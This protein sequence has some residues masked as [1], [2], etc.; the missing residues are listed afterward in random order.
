MAEDLAGKLYDELYEL[1]DHRLPGVDGI[2]DS[3]IHKIDTFLE[4]Y[5]NYYDLWMV[6]G[7]AIRLG[8]FLSE[9]SFDDAIDTY[10]IAMCIDPFD[11]APY[12]E[13]AD[14]YDINSQFEKA[15]FYYENALKLGE[16]FYTIINLSIL[17]SGFNRQDDAVNLIKESKYFDCNE[18][19]MDTYHEILDGKWTSFAIEKE[20]IKISE[21][22][23]DDIISLISDDYNKSIIALDKIERSNNIQYSSHLL[24]LSDRY[25]SCTN[26]TERFYLTRSLC[27]ALIA[28]NQQDLPVTLINIYSKGDDIVKMVV[29]Q[30][31]YR[32]HDEG[33]VFQI[34]SGIIFKENNY[35]LIRSLV[36]VLG[37]K[38]LNKSEGMLLSLLESHTNIFVIRSI[39][40]VLRGL[41]SDTAFNSIKKYISDSHWLIR[42]SALRSLEDIVL[43]EKKYNMLL[44]KT[45]DING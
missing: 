38:C 33:I 40:R 22:T 32:I 30:A 34:V 27:D 28:I 36:F 35:R 42:L 4:L 20:N 2:P 43:R 11:Y 7:R 45:E 16:D 41:D 5:P 26:K 12:L 3:F 19:V 10:D 29:I 1:S 37:E 24:E 15:L 6:R 14:I 18:E 44:P 23:T 31:L 21:V 39:I 9:Y 13:I 8:T 17:Y 25:L